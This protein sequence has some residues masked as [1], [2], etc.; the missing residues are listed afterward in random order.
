MN[1]ILWTNFVWV[2]KIMFTQ[3]LGICFSFVIIF[4]KKNSLGIQFVVVIC[5]IPL[6]FLY[7]WGGYTYL[8]IQILVCY[9]IIEVA[10]NENQEIE[11]T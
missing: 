3:G 1:N 5:S 4:I 9:S 2:W 11:E 7:K 10:L 8:D 6:D